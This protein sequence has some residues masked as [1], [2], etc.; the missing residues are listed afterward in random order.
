MLLNKYCIPCNH[1]FVKIS[2]V[3][4]RILKILFILNVDPFDH[5]SKYQII[6]GFSS[7]VLVF[8]SSIVKIDL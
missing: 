8:D 4:V 3:I 7:L 6:K 1:S 5:F 2:I